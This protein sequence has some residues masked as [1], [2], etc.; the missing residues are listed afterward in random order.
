MPATDKQGLLLSHEAEYNG[1]HLTL[2][3]GEPKFGLCVPRSWLKC[4]GCSRRV[5]VVYGGK[6]RLFR[7]RKCYGLAYRSTRLNWGDRADTNA[8][9]LALKICAANAIF[10]TKFPPRERPSMCT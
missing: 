2:T 7:C 1:R 3:V 9:K 5:R 8:N 4:L 10:R 6:R